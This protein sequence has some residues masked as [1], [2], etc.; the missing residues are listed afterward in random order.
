[1]EYINRDELEMLLKESSEP[2]VSIYMTT[3]KGWEKAKENAI[4]FKNLLSEAEEWLNFTGINA[5]EK[6]RLLKPAKKLLDNSHYWANQD[7][8]LACFLN[9]NFYRYYRLPL[10]FTEIAVV[11]RSFHLKPLFSL[12]TMDWR[13]YILAISKKDIRLLRATRTFCEEVDLSAL[14][15]ELEAEFSEEMPGSNL[16]FHTRAPYAGRTRTAVFFGHGGDIENIQKEHLLKYFR[17]ID[18]E[19][20]NYMKTTDAPLV[21]AC[22]DYLAPLYREASSYPVLL[23]EIV[24]GNPENRSNQEIHEK[25]WSIVKPYFQQPVDEIKE[26]YLELK[27]TGKTSNNILELVVAAHQ[28]KI[29]DLLFVPG[30]QQWGRYNPQTGEATPGNEPTRGSEDL[31]DIIVTQSFLNKSNI[32]ALEAEMMP[33]SSPAAALFRW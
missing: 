18:R 16:Q 4:R 24:R 10:Q 26:R 13:F 12:L 22:V 30:I 1:M 31:I 5:S 3:Q 25:A 9:P 7:E 14:L 20:P 15:D 17:F 2:G 27:G 23:E 19:L 29:S 32:Y 8:G 28:G 33:D 6:E 11:K 21:L